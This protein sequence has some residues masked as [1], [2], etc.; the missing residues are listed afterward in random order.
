LTTKRE[1]TCDDCYFRQQSL[2]ALLVPA[3]CPT[4]RL[5]VRG[6]LAPPRQPRL[7]PLAQRRAEPAA[8]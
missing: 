6:Q 3:P 1:L 8:A 4:F 5:A 7:V 2:C